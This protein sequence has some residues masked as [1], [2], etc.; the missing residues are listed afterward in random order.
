V[1][2]PL[3]QVVGLFGVAGSARASMAIAPLRSARASAAVRRTGVIDAGF[4]PADEF[5]CP[6]QRDRRRRRFR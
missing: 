5:A 3:D 2:A 6:S 1:G 4:V